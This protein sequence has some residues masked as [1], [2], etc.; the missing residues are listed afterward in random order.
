MRFIGFDVTKCLPFYTMH[1]VFEGVA[2]F[3][4][5][6]LL[7]HIIDTKSYF[8]LEQLN[9]IIQSHQLWVFRKRH[10]AI[11]NSNEVKLLH[12]Q[13]NRYAALHVHQYLMIFILLASQMM[14]L[15]GLLPFMIGKFIDFDDNH[16]GCFLTL[17]TICNL[18]C[19]FEATLEDSIYFGLI[20]KTYWESF[21]LTLYFL[22]KMAKIFSPY[23]NV[24][25]MVISY[26]I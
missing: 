2:N 25:N 3:H 15:M 14:T 9:N 16:W 7:P 18:V 6:N 5:I 24:Y 11:S 12:H 19:A 10:K 20:I 22:K 4:L 23:S 21:R 13:T 8:T 1:T 26:W 17:C